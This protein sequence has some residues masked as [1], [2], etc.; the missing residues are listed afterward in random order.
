M[1]KKKRLPY[2]KLFVDD[3]ARD[4]KHLTTE[5][6]G[7]YL[8]LLMKAWEYPSVSL[9]DDDEMLARHAKVSRSKW[10]KMKKV[11]MAFW[12][13]DGRSKRWV[14]KRLK[15]E[16]RSAL[17]K[18][19]VAKDAAVSGWTKRKKGNAEAMRTQCHTFIA[20]EERPKGLSRRSSAQKKSDLDLIR[21]AFEHA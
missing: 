18:S 13:L 1:S 5:E 3:Y 15:E 12:T 9:D 10:A 2:I 4:T 20:S 14:Q 8:L 16:R 11:I 7:A 17:G 21:E 19:H 6:H